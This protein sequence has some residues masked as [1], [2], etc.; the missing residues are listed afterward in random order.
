[1]S[2][3]DHPQPLGQLTEIFLQLANC[4]KR[5]KVSTQ[6]LSTFLTHVLKT[7]SR[8]ATTPS[9]LNLSP[10]AVAHKVQGELDDWQLKP[11][12]G[13]AIYTGFNVE[14]LQLYAAFLNTKSVE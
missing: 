2:T 10:A 9:N 11:A 14:K 12:M 13:F 8:E 7:L 4:C 5:D 1:M 6:R 3:L